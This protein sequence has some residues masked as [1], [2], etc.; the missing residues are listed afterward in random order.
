MDIGWLADANKF[1]P[2][3]LPKMQVPDSS[4]GDAIFTS[5]KYFYLIFAAGYLLFP[6]LLTWF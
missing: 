5:G 3:S 2:A 1:H 6:K 4:S